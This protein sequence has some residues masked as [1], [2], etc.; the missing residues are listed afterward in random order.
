M[1]HKLA[2]LLV[3]VSPYKLLEPGTA[4]PNVISTEYVNFLLL[5]ELSY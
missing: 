4:F 5:I 3:D 2:N 1:L